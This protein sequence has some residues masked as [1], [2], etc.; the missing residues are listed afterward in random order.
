MR[1][2]QSIIIDNDP[3]QNYETNCFLRK[4]GNFFVVPILNNL[5]TSFRK[6]IV[7]T[8]KTSEHIVKNATTH[9]ALET[10][11][12]HKKKHQGESLL[13]KFFRTFWALTSNSK[14]V[15]NRLK[16]VKREIKA[17]LLDRIENQ[18]RKEIKILSIASG[19]S[20]AIYEVLSDI[21]K[22][23]HS[24]VKIEAVF[25]DK[26][27]DA[28]EYSKKLSCDHDNGCS[29]S[30]V[31]DTIGNYMR[32]SQPAG[33]FDIVEMVGLLDYFANEKAIQVFSYIWQALKDGGIMITANIDD[34]PERKFVTKVIGWP[35]IYR[36]ASGLI[37]LAVK[38]GFS[39]EKIHAIYE[40]L[41]IH[42]VL[43]ARK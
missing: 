15:R 27:P 5:P 28:I 14:A 31:N 30:W 25:L 22:T 35:M 42:S 21:K 34:N 19:S 23:I 4:V 6:L 24:E 13:G 36:T 41:K 2:A 38:A 17:E 12:S 40:P 8:H 29:Y 16:L 32:R 3:V 20:R 11:Y 1:N 37:S 39:E 33:E 18:G 9:S 26:N 43:I 10:L 7:K